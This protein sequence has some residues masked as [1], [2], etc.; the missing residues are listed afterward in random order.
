MSSSS[1]SNDV[2]RF[3]FHFHRRRTVLV[4]PP[5]KPPTLPWTRPFRRAFQVSTPNSSIGSNSS[6]VCTLTNATF[7]FHSR[8]LNQPLADQSP[9]RR[10]CVYRCL[11]LVLAHDWSRDTSTAGIS[12]T[13]MAAC[14]STSW[15]IARRALQVSQN[16]LPATSDTFR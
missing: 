3:I 2:H 5:S 12:S 16:R 6:S 10:H 9:I 11:Q 14:V 8:I 15:G 13:S 4:L 1:S 7:S